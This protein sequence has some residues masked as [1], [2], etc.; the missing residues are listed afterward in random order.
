MT[1]STHFVNIAALQNQ[2]YRSLEGKTSNNEIISAI[3]EI[4]GN[5]FKSLHI[6]NEALLNRTQAP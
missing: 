1:K 2:Y 4:L 6:S 5:Q 3:D